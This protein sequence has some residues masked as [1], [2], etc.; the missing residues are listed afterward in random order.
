MVNTRS[1]SRRNPTVLGGTRV[2]WSTSLTSKHAG[3]RC[4][5]TSLTQ[6]QSAPGSPSKRVG[7]RLEG[8]SVYFFAQVGPFV[9]QWH[10]GGTTHL[11]V[12]M[13]DF[14]RRQHAQRSSSS[15]VRRSFLEGVQWSHRAPHRWRPLL[16]SPPALRS[17]SIRVHRCD[18][19]ETVVFREGER[20]PRAVGRPFGAVARDTRHPHRA[21]GSSSSAVQSNRPNKIPLR[22]GGNVA[23]AGRAAEQ[24]VRFPRFHRS[25]LRNFMAS[26][27]TRNRPK[28]CTGVNSAGHHWQCHASG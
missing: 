14:G 27:H 19:A 1:R 7:S 28:G 13:P 9:T 10:N 16:W 26:R 17:R 3:Q 2:T 18:L 21:A 20:D 4:A 6:N 5:W 11:A 25:C 12:F 15:A 8:A 23:C 22:A 24:A